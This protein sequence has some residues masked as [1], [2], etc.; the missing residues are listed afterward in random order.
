M[1]KELKNTYHRFVDALIGAADEFLIDPN[2]KLTYAEAIGATYSFMRIFENCISEIAPK[3]DEG[4][5]DE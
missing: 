4:E 1:S 3:T 5:N 2:N